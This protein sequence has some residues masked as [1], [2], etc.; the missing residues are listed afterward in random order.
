MME[1]DNII[2]KVICI[3]SYNHYKFGEV[4]DAMYDEHLNYY[5]VYSDKSYAMSWVTFESYFKK[6]GEYREQ[7]IK[8]ILT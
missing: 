3:C 7:R 6:L 8:E 4:Y 2:I 1:E 5:E